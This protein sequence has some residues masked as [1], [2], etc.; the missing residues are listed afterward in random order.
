MNTVNIEEIRKFE[1]LAHEWW[2]PHGKFKP[3]HKFNPIRIQY[4][5]EKL[6]Q[7]ISKNTNSLFPLKK[8]KILDIGC[9]GGLISE[10]LSRLG[11]DVTG[12]DA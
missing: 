5:K 4:I 6:T 9:G 11:A 10:P 3:L 12:V 7:Y 2:D 1:K 8:I